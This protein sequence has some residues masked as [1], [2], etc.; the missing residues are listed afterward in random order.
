MKFTVT[1]AAALAAMLAS[2]TSAFA[3]QDGKLVIW[4]GGGKGTAKLRQVGEAFAKD[5]GVEVVVEE[6][7]PAVEKFQ[8]A[9]ST[10]DGPDIM[11]WA[12]DRFGE[13]AAGG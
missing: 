2:S 7:D 11:L 1:I 3:F 12:H 8:Q 5:L 13:W 6:V 9:A 4:M 10:G